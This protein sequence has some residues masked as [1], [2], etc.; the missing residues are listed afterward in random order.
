MRFIN[1]EYKNQQKNEIKENEKETE[2]SEV[3]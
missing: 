2:P 3:F 1:K